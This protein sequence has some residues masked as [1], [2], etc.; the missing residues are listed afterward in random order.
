MYC[1]DGILNTIMQNMDEIVKNFKTIY[2]HVN[3][4]S[5]RG[6]YDILGIKNKFLARIYRPVY[7]SG[8]DASELITIFRRSI[9]EII[10][11]AH[12]R[13]IHK[14]QTL[15]TR[16]GTH[17]VSEYKGNEK[18]QVSEFYYGNKN[19]RPHVS[20]GMVNNSLLKY[21]TKQIIRNLIYTVPKKSA[22][23]NKLEMDRFRK[24]T[25]SIKGKY[26]AEYDIYL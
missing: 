26:N 21:D 2:R 10:K 17:Y 6:N 1:T 11:N 9:Y 13:P 25:F 5:K 23:I 22:P 12:G 19:W 8:D 7:D 24:I 20:I 3:L 15:N 14:A 16:K 4:L 18:L